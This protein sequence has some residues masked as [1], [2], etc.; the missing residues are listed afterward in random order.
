MKAA[1]S[2]LGCNGR[3]VVV[4]PASPPLYS[5][6]D[7]RAGHY[8]RYT[9]RTLAATLRKAG[10]EVEDI[11]YFD[12]VSYLRYL[13]NYRVLRRTVVDDS[14]VKLFDRVLV[15]LSRWLSVRAQG[16]PGKNVFAVAR[17]GDR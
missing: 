11:G 16:M 8:R 1:G 2:L 4:G 9:T 3:L 14:S 10:F 7:F 6:L 13:L 17:L 15:P 12:H 5:E